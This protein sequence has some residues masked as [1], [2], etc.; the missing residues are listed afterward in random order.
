MIVRGK[1]SA[2]SG[3][4]RLLFPFGVFHK[5]LKGKEVIAMTKEDLFYVFFMLWVLTGGFYPSGLKPLSRP[6]IFGLNPFISKKLRDTHH[7][8]QTVW[9]SQTYTKP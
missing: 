8:T 9:M 5:P 6:L 1:M 7:G 2:R 3:G 4:F